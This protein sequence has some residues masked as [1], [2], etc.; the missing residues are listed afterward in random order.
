M[1]TI[2]TIENS[3]PAVAHRIRQLLE[4]DLK[5]NGVKAIQKFDPKKFRVNF[6]YF[7]CYHPKVAEGFNRLEQM[8]Q[9]LT[10]AERGARYLKN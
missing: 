4:S 3:K 1:S 7:P 9:R 6:F 10:S 8:I 5:T 2:K